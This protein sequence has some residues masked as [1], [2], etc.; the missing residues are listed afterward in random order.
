[1]LKIKG[2]EIQQRLTELALEAVGHYGAPY[3]RGFGDGDNEHADRPGLRATAPRRHYFNMRKTSIYG[4]SNEIQRNIIAK[5]VLGLLKLASRPTRDSGVRGHSMDFNFTEEQTMLRDTRRALSR[6]QLR[7]RQRRKAVV[8][9]RRRL[10]SGCLARPSP[11][12]R[13]P[14]RAVQRRRMAALAAA[15][16]ENMIVMEE[17]GRASWSSPICRP[18]S[19]A[20][21][22]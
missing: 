10:A 14:G 7:L 21:A 13:H 8:S 1:M 2:T 12:T 22:S 3:F 9:Q 6:R 4:G 20:A 18:S 16:I 11:R 19:S 17:F 5:M 15:P